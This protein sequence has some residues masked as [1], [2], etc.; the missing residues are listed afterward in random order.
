MKKV[1]KRLLTALTFMILIIA[2]LIILFTNKSIPD[3]IISDV[4]M[5]SNQYL[6]TI[7]YLVTIKN[8]GETFVLID[9]PGENQISGLTLSVLFTND[10][11]HP[12]IK[13]QTGINQYTIGRDQKKLEPGQSLTDTIVVI[14]PKLLDEG[15]YACLIIDPDNRVKEMDEDNNFSCVPLFSK[16]EMESMK[17]R[18]VVPIEEYLG[19]FALGFPGE[20]NLD[21]PPEGKSWTPASPEVDWQLNNKVILL[22]NGILLGPIVGVPYAYKHVNDDLFWISTNQFGEYGGYTCCQMYVLNSEIS[23]LSEAYMLS[24][25]FG[26]DGY[27][28]DHDG[29]FINDSTYEFRRYWNDESFKADSAFGTILIR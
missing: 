12:E 25:T 6:K 17:L 5:G 8:I 20:A 9:H 18:E 19:H 28:I 16:D 4:Q 21:A 7:S 26:E 3:V 27:Y 10:K 14:K 24:E 11:D 22:E 1:Q 13:Q 23:T 2:V 15:E 29:E